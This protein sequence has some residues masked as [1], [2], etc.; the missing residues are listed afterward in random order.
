MLQ[1]VSIT[2]L[3]VH[4]PKVLYTV[5]KT[6]HT[7]HMS[8]FENYLFGGK[9]PDLEYLNIIY[10]LHSFF[11]HILNN[12]IFGVKVKTKNEV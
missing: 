9:K 4:I 3:A 7:F 6:V 2:S 12:G 1:I 5:Q 10:C 11:V 8:K